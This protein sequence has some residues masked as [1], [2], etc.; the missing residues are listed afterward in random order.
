MNEKNSIKPLKPLW[1]FAV[2]FFT[3]VSC[4]SIK[5][6][7]IF[8]EGTLD[9]ALATAKEKNKYL[10]VISTLEGCGSCDMF[11]ENLNRNIELKKELATDFLVYESDCLQKENSYL[12]WAFN[13][14]ASP[15]FFVFSSKGELLNIINNVTINSDVGHIYLKMIKEGKTTIKANNFRSRFSLSEGEVIAFM[16]KIIKAYK[17][18]KNPDSNILSLKEAY[19]L[20]KETIIQEPYF[21]N[22]YLAGALAYRLQDSLAS[23]QHYNR[24][25]AFNDGYSNKLFEVLIEEM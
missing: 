22:N 17:I 12:S 10:F 11:F 1:I 13:S 23:V 16:N 19:N 24:A 20:A 8:I 15:T 2:I 25:K 6:E 14:I 4:N 21:F 7:P 9:Q 18:Y 3:M 5:K